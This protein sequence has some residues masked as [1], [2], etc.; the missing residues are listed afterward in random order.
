[1]LEHQ[2]VVSP[3]LLRAMDDLALPYLYSLSQMQAIIGQRT[4]VKLHWIQDYGSASDPN[5]LAAGIL[6]KSMFPR[7]FTSDAKDP[8]G[9]VLD[10]GQVESVTVDSENL[11]T[12]TFTKKFATELQKDQVCV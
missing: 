2:G 7:D 9:V 10:N 11:L 8:E 5:V 4:F 12:I 3:K 1:L 6:L